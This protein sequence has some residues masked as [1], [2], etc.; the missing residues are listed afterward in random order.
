MNTKTAKKIRR[1]LQR[2]NVETVAAFRETVLHLGF[3]QRF[4]FSIRIL[5]KWL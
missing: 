3:W 5:L 4:K 1:I 2:R